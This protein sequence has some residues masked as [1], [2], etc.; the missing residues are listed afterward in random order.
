[1]L[2]QI[3]GFRGQA[4]CRYHWN[5]RQIDPGCHGNKNLWILTEKWLKLG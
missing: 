3:G 5:L 2:H 4:F 1:M